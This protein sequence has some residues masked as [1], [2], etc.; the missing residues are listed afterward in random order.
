[1]GK[2]TDRYERL[3]KGRKGFL[4]LRVQRHSP[5]RGGIILVAGVVFAVFV[6]VVFCAVVLHRQQ[7]TG[8]AAAELL[9]QGGDIRLSAK[10]FQDGRAHFYRY[11]TASG[12]EIRFFVIQSPDGVIRSAF[13]S[14]ELCYRQRRGYRQ[15]GQAMVCNN[16]RRTFP[17]SGINM[18]KGHCNPSPVERAVE[19]DQ[20]L[21]KAPNL[22]LGAAYF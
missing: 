4:T 14:C 22:E 9:P 11:M 1:M 5:S 21:L 18:I 2:R 3:R 6:V 19:G 16:C 13:D 8:L 12:R 20:V 10:Q 17:S 15:A 7:D